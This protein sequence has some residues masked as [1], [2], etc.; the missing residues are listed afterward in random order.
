[1]PW[2][3]QR[4]R[5]TAPPLDFSLDFFR[6]R[7]QA[8]HILRSST[9]LSWEHDGPVTAAVFCLVR[10]LRGVRLAVG[11]PAHPLNGAA[12]EPLLCSAGTGPR[13]TLGETRHGDLASV[14]WCTLLASGGRVL[15][16]MAAGAAALR[17]LTRRSYVS[18]VPLLVGHVAWVGFVGAS[19]TLGSD[20]MADDRAGA[21]G[22][23]ACLLS[24]VLAY[25]LD[26]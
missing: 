9:S 24:A 6:H 18:T 17:S 5:E 19:E 10:E 7:S 1:M 22:F 12:S 11:A 26:T 3:V 16:V 2:G 25:R 4:G 13:R 23:G 8:P 21:P 20:T 14:R 15:Y